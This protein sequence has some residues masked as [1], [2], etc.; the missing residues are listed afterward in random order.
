MKGS[1]PYDF[2]TLDGRNA[3]RDAI[4][5]SNLSAELKAA[6]IGALDAG[7]FPPLVKR[8]KG[9]PPDPAWKQM[10][11]AIRG[12][13]ID[14]NAPRGEQTAEIARLA[15]EQNISVAAMR[16]RIFRPGRKREKP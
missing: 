11:K 3:S 4:A 16:D 13:L 14:R 15:A 5:R 10:Q 6:L 8:S 2:S 12:M 1:N 7:S 9:R